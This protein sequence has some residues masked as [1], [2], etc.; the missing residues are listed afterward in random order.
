MPRVRLLALPCLLLVAVLVAAC[1]G[2]PGAGG[3]AD[4]AQAVPAGTAIYIEGVVRPEG[5]QRADVL[6]AA[7]KVLRTSDP[8]A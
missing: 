5:D 1:G 7:G 2:A 4:P 3:D 6:D 8:E